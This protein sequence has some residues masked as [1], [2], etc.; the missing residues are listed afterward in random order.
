[1]GLIPKEENTTPS[2]KIKIQT[3]LNC[4]DFNPDFHPKHPLAT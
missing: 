3:A 1:M 2:N 4:F